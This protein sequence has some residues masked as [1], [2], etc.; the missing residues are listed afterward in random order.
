M[1]NFGERLSLNDL[2]FEKPEDQI[3]RHM[4]IKITNFIKDEKK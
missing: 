1:D 3:F 4:S 2:G